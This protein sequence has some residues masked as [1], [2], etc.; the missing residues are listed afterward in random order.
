MSMHSELQNQTSVKKSYTD[1]KKTIN[2]EPPNSSPIQEKVLVCATTA[3][4]G[5]I[6]VISK[7]NSNN[8]SEY[9][10]KQREEKQLFDPSAKYSPN[11]NESENQ[12]DY[13][14][15]LEE[16]R[17]EQENDDTIRLSS[18]M[19]SSPYDDSFN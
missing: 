3:G 13:A 16:M 5:G 18:A 10:H 2:S 12:L 8:I 4:V 17:K 1:W 6:R 11:E 14:K 15:W 9:I 7:N 19:W